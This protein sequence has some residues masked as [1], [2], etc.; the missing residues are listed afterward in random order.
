MDVAIGWC[1]KEMTAH[2]SRDKYE[3]VIAVLDHPDRPDRTGS[4]GWHDTLGRETA[5]EL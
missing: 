3:R 2:H 4:V 1:R 5:E